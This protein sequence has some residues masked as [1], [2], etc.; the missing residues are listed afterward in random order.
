MSGIGGKLAA[1]DEAYYDPKEPSENDIVGG[2]WGGVRKQHLA[3]AAVKIGVLLLAATVKIR[4]LPCFY[5]LR[6]GASPRQAGHHRPGTGAGAASPPL[7]AWPRARGF[8]GPSGGR[9]GS[10]TP[11]PRAPA[12]QWEDCGASRGGVRVP[13]SAHCLAHGYWGATTRRGGR[14]RLRQH[15]VPPPRGLRQAQLP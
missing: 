9:P 10:S 15:R 11:P 13:R 14:A 8:R 6:A 12:L 5:P 1:A 4:V 7:P 3:T 2:G